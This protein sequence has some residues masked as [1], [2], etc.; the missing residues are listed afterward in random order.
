MVGERETRLGS[1]CLY[2]KRRNSDILGKDRKGGMCSEDYAPNKNGSV[3]ACVYVRVFF[4][5]G[6]GEERGCCVT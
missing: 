4:L 3:Y 6:R 5:K 2:K 1:W